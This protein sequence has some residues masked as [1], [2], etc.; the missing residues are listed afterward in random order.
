MPERKEYIWTFDSVNRDTNHNPKDILNPTND[1][2]IPLNLSVNRPTITSM[3]LAT[4]EIPRVQGTIER[5]WNKLYGSNGFS[6]QS[7]TDSPQYKFIIQDKVWKYIAT[8]PDRLN[9]IV[10][11]DV[12]DP[13]EPIFETFKPHLL[14]THVQYWTWD[15]TIDII[16]TSETIVLAGNGMLSPDVNIISDVSFSLSLSTPLDF[17]NTSATCFGYV[18]YPTLPSP[19]FVSTLLT[20]ELN[21]SF[22]EETKQIRDN[23]FQVA[24][25]LK[26]GSYTV[27]VPVATYNQF[28][29]IGLLIDLVLVIKGLNNI[30][31]YLGFGVCDAFFANQKKPFTICA[32]Q[33]PS[34]ASYISVTSGKYDPENLGAEISFQCNRFWFEPAPVNV[35]SSLSLVEAQ[36][37]LQ[38]ST[39]FG[40]VHSL[41][42]PPGLYTPFSLA[43]TLTSLFADVWLEGNVEVLWDS[44]NRLFSFISQASKTFSLEFQVSSFTNVAKRLGF[45]QIRYTTH[46]MYM[47]DNPIPVP[48]AF[49]TYKN[50]VYSSSVCNISVDQQKEKYAYSLAK[51]AAIPSVTTVVTVSGTNNDCL[52]ITNKAR[53]HGFNVGDI[54]N[55]LADSQELRY[56][57]KTV[58]SGTEF[59]VDI[60]ATVFPN[61]EFDIVGQEFTD[62]KDQMILTLNT[63]YT[64]L[65][66]GTKVVLGCEENTY[67]GIVTEVIAATSTTIDFSPNTIPSS[68]IGAPLNLDTILQSEVGVYT[69]ETPKLNL[70]LSTKNKSSPIPPVLLGFADEDILWNSTDT[71]ESS[72]RYRILSTTY[73]LVQLVEPI[74]TSRIEHNY[75][76]DNKI[77]ILGKI[78]LTPTPL[79]TL[80]RF[81]PLTVTFSSPVR[82]TYIHIRILNLDHSLYQLHGQEFSG[83][84]VLHTL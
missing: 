21:R 67:I 59:E 24:Y 50:V 36:Y 53:A 55:V 61:I 73:V 33:I 70:L 66:V 48:V 16:A 56:P 20:G 40:S 42:I 63:V 9:S 25:D 2:K 71:F 77:D 43:S 34:N 44:N 72:Y 1:I 84:I 8:L 47:S 52:R 76:G 38:F 28:K 29:K 82:L 4:I 17:N 18:F 14:A 79:V 81:F 80:N 57:V 27:S 32:Q 65:N 12:T 74:G 39:Q 13:Y 22:Q 30:A 26:K 41:V 6:V 3:E 37:I 23:V 60:C 11:V 5:T 10:S 46:T 15:E 62:V 35:T 69:T 58:L 68:C 19:D 54:V 75:L 83:T 31:S 51:P 78:V 49:D 7:N 45:K 64:N